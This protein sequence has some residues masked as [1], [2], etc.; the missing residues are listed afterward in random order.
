M[1]TRTAS[2]RDETAETLAH[3]LSP[4][5]TSAML[6]VLVAED[7]ATARL[8]L[9]SLLSSDPEITVVGQARNGTHHR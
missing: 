4:C 3:R 1:R 9:V 6:R 7:S 8:L 5:Y 2:S